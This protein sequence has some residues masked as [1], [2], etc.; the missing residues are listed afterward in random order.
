MVAV[1]PAAA[2]V[3]PAA[4]V[5]PAAVVTPAAAVTPVVVVTPAAAVVTPVAAAV[6]P[7]VVVAAGGAD[8]SPTNSLSRRR[9]LGGVT[10]QVSHLRNAVRPKS[11]REEPVMLRTMAKGQA[12][13]IPA[14][15]WLV[16]SA[17]FTALALPAMAQEI[18]RLVV[19]RPDNRAGSADAA[20]VIAEMIAER[21]E[22]AAVRSRARSIAP[23]GAL[24]VGADE[25]LMDIGAHAFIGSITGSG[26]V[27]PVAVPPVAR[28]VAPT[29]PAATPAA[30]TPQPQRNWGISERFSG[31]MRDL[32]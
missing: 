28:P 23:Q 21:S 7:A 19:F 1:T 5:T 20:T 16:A 24:T 32:P 12:K 6:T 15:R 25:L 10:R 22:S 11:R 18:D 14:T 29:P 27:L 13:R 8:D 17:A 4:A 30:A 31:E 9:L 3:T 26:S 2:V